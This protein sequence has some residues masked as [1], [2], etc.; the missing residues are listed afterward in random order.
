MM[1]KTSYVAVLGTEEQFG[2]FYHQGTKAFGENLNKKG[3]A[4]QLVRRLGLTTPRKDPQKLKVDV[5]RLDIV[6]GQLKRVP[7]GTYD[8]QPYLER[9]T[10]EEYADELKDILSDVPEEFWPFVKSQSWDRGHSSGNEEVISYARELVGELAPCIAAF[11]KKKK[12]K[13]PA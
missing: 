10:D 6:Q 3:L 13:T 2:E 9:M 11:E 4:E 8:V 12:K 1:D 5:F 7:V